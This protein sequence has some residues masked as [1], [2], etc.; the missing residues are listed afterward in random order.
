MPHMTCM[1]LPDFHAIYNIADHDINRDLLTKI[2]R[3]ID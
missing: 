2:V 3:Y 1:Q